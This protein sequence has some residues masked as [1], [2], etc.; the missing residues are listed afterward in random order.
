MINSRLNEWG[1]EWESNKDYEQD[2]M[3]EVYSYYKQY[4]ETGKY[5]YLDSIVDYI[6]SAES[7]DNRETLKT[8]VYLASHQAKREKN[9][10][11]REEMLSNGWLTLNNENAHRIKGKIQ[12][13]AI[14][15]GAFF[16]FKLTDMFKVFINANGYAYLM[17]PRASRK[18]YLISNLENAYYKLV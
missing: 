5:P 12:V 4:V 14:G 3:P 17:K 11:H 2:A 16:N 6:A 15:Q 1:I 9:N 10:N 13:S 8:Q 18:G 7:I